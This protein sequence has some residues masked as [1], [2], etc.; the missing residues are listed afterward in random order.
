MINNLKIFNSL[1]KISK[2][3]IF[4]LENTVKSK[5][6]ISCADNFYS[7]ISNLLNLLKDDEFSIPEMNKDKFDLQLKILHEIDDDELRRLWVK[8]VYDDYE[9]K[10]YSLYKKNNYLTYTP[11]VV[12]RRIKNT[13]YAFVKLYNTRKEHKVVA[14][15]GKIKQA[16]EFLK[17]YYSNKNK[18]CLPVYAIN[19]L[20][21]KY[22]Q[23]GFGE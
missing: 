4:A 6:Y 19:K 22:L 11:K 3:C 16:H 23:G 5:V 7:N 15:F 13:H 1:L 14:V 9:S 10:G 21:K 8:K 17:E 18:Y 12:V 2:K 20:T